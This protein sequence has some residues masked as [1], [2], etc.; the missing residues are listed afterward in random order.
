MTADSTIKRLREI[1]HRDE[2]KAVYVR[3]DDL[4]EL[5]AERDALRRALPAPPSRKTR[6]RENP[7]C[8]GC[9]RLETRI[10]TLEARA[11]KAEAWNRDM[12]LRAAS[13][14]VLDEYREMSA[15]LAAAETR[16]EKAKAD[17]RDAYA[18]G[19]EYAAEHIEAA[20]YPNAEC[21]KI[22]AN[23]R[24]HAAFDREKNAAFD[25]ETDT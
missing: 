21:A 4:R 25:R 12:V 16:A 11:E 2:A 1:A 15:K 6:M 23:I 20:M 24:A 5:I 14:G 3:A 13:G 17:A 10:E 8:K 7:M 22:I 18:R 19:I 9:A